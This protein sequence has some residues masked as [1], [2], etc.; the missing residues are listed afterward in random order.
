MS[1][2][3]ARGVRDWRTQGR[4]IRANEIPA[5]AGASHAGGEARARGSADGGIDQ[6]LTVVVGSAGAGKSVLV[7]SWARARSRA[8]TAWLSCDQADA[9]PVRFW[10]RFIEA[11]Q[12]T[13]PGFGGEAAELL[14]I[15]RVMSADAIASLANDAAKLPGRLSS[16][17]SIMRP[18]RCLGT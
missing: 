14:V 18:E 17:T 12:L 5:A 3:A 6:C 4:A 10:S 8:D 16:T 9:N 1:R 2:A 7:S 11:V 15:D 13:E